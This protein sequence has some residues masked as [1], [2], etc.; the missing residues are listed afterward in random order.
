MKI[1]C[2][3]LASGKSERFGKSKSK[4]FHKLNGTP[5]IEFTLKNFLNHFNKDSI[6]ITIPKKIT[7]NEKKFLVNFTNNELIFGGKTRFESLKNAL[8][9]IDINKYEAV[10]IHDAAR[11]I[12]PKH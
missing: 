6:Y 10:M 2:I 9:S 12:T 4:I 3:I 11:P 8:K 5:V 1:A 7:K